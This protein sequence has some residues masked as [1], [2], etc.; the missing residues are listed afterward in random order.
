MIESR[1][2]GKNQNFFDK[3]KLHYFLH[4]SN[5][6]QYREAFMYLNLTSF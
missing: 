1:S 6:S 4:L 5:G 2:A 3:G